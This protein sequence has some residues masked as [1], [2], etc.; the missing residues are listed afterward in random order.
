MNSRPPRDYP[1]SPY[2]ASIDPFELYPE[3]QVGSEGALPPGQYDLPYLRQA[4][5]EQVGRFLASGGVIDPLNLVFWGRAT[6]DGLTGLLDRLSNWV[7]AFLSAPLWGL[8]ETQG[9]RRKLQT[10]HSLQQATPRPWVS[11]VLI[12]T[13]VIGSWARHHV[14][15][16]FPFHAPGNW[17]A[18]ALAGA[19]TES[20]GVRRQFPYIWHKVNDWAEARNMLADDLRSLLD[21]E[22]FELRIFPTE[23]RWQGKQFDGRVVFVHLH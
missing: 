13:R 17:G 15:I 3:A 12:L 21:E 2:L 10:V 23:G 5:V 20:V 8:A 7:P 16:M 1:F 9:S 6:L 14:R 19:H 22:A 4:D 18:V 11:P